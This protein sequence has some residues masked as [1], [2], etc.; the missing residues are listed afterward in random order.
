[1]AN[2]LVFVGLG[3]AITN[4]SDAQDVAQK[5]ADISQAAVKMIGARI[6]TSSARNVGNGSTGMEFISLISYDI[7]IG[8]GEILGWFPLPED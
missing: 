7:E 8:D 4:S 1:M 5:L 6:R 2:P 3:M